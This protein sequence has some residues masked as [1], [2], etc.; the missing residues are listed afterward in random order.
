MGRAVKEIQI[1]SSFLLPFDS[2]QG[3]RG[4]HDMGYLGMASLKEHDFLRHFDQK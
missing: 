2:S 3:E 4:T 1:N